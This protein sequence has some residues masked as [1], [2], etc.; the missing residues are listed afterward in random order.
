M[1]VFS[2]YFDTTTGGKR[3]TESY[4]K[5]VA[6]IKNEAKDVLFLTDIPEGKNYWVLVFDNT[7]L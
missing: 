3:E 2:G 1:Q 6:E 4:K 5:I 7:M